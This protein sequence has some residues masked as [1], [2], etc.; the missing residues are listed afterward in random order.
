MPGTLI[1]ADDLHCRY[2]GPAPP[3]F[4][5]V[6]RAGGRT[7]WTDLLA[8]TRRS[9][10]TRACAESRAA[11]A[12]RRSLLNARSAVSDPWLGRLVHRLAEARRQAVE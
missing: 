9:G 5:R 8:E 3:A 10:A 4:L 1:D 7:G 2:D 11:A 12:R 6:G